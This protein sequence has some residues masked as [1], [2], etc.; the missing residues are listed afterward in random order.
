MQVKKQQFEPDMEQ[1]IG[2]VASVD[3]ISKGR[4]LGASLLN[5]WEIRKK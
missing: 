3:D 4:N 2:S 5:Q 1:W